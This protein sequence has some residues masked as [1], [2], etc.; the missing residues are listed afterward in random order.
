MTAL[1]LGTRNIGGALAAIWHRIGCGRIALAN[2]VAAATS[3]PQI[4]WINSPSPQPSAAS[5]K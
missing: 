3:L 4:G 5:P 1:G 2:P